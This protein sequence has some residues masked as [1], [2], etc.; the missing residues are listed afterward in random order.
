VNLFKRHTGMYR[1]CITANRVDRQYVHTCTNMADSFL[2]SGFLWLVPTNRHDF[3]FIRICRDT[4][5]I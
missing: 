5:I 3:S 1:Y 2:S 4:V